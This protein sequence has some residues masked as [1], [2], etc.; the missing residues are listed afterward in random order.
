MMDAVEKKGNALATRGFSL[1]MEN[2][3]VQ[4]IFCQCPKEQADQETGWNIPGK[5]ANRADK[6]SAG[7]EEEDDRQPDNQYGNGTYMGK[8]L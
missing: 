7:E 8:E 6:E 2:E 4:G 3:A 1:V 5:A